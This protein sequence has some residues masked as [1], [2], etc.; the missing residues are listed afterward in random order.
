[1]S[2]EMIPFDEDEDE[3]WGIW[4]GQCQACDRYGPVNDM[5]L[6]EDCAGKFERDL[7]RLREWD[8]SASAFGLPAEAREE[9]RRQVIAES[10]AALEL[11]AP[12]AGTEKSGP[13]RNESG[14]RTDD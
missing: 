7:I 6:C 5:S 4:D 10:G 2:N 13:H 12:P 9:L 8:Y 11:I 3:P 14:E 1:M